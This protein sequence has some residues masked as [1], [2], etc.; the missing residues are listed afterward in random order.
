VSSEWGLRNILYFCDFFLSRFFHSLVFSVGY[1]CKMVHMGMIVNGSVFLQ[2]HLQSYPDR[3]ILTR[4]VGCV[5]LWQMES[6]CNCVW[7]VATIRDT[8]VLDAAIFQALKQCLS[9]VFYSAGWCCHQQRSHYVC[10]TC[11]ERLN[12]L[13][14]LGHQSELV[15]FL[16]LS[17][18]IAD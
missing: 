12:W 5:W 7:L 13:Q 1:D 16:L 4:I 6:W 9:F 11:K 18:V 10:L 2:N 8:W 15:F 3:Y 14:L 17:H